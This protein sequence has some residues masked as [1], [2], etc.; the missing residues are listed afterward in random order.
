MSLKEELYKQ[1][2]NYVNKRLQTV[3]EIIT[4]NQ[5]ALESE[6]K[7]SAGDKHE[8][9]RAMLQLE[10]EKASQQIE[11]VQQMKE[12]LAR[13]DPFKTSKNVRLGSIIFTDKANYFLCISAGQLTIDKNI[14]F[15]ISVSSPIGKL[16]LG[17]QKGDIIS[18]NGNLIKIVAVR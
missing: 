16:L 5:K 4:S 1:S 11:V 9:G 8:T 2:C 6:T 14:F 12:I 13:I 17:S 7:S 10:M 3:E 15:A 18:F